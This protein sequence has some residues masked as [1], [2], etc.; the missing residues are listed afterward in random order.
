MGEKMWGGGQDVSICMWCA[1]DML[2]LACPMCD[3]VWPMLFQY[4]IAE[5]L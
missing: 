3:T 4:K 5:T 1:C 2:S